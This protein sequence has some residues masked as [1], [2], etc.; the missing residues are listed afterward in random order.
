[1]P[2][3]RYRR[4]E[5]NIIMF[6]KLTQQLVSKVINDYQNTDDM[7]VRARYGSLEAITSIIVNLVLFAVKLVIGL[8]LHSIAVIA[9][10]MH[11]LSD[12]G[13]SIVVLVGFKVAR[14]PGDREHPFGHGRAEPIAALIMAVIL[15]VAGFELFKSAAA[16]LWN[17]ELQVIPI[18]WL[19]ISLL[20]IS[21]LIKEITAQFA[22][23]LGRMIQSK[24]LKADFWHHRSD[25]LSTLLVLAALAG[26]HFGWVRFDGLAGLLVALIVIYSGYAIAR[27]AISPLLGERPDSELLQQIE[28]VALSLDGVQGVHDV[29][30]H[31]YGQINLISLHIEVDEDRPVLELHDLSELVEET[32]EKKLGGSTVVHIDPVSKSHE[33]YTEIHDAVS[34]LTDKNEKIAGFHDL[35]IIGHGSRVK[36]IFDI[37]LAENILQHETTTITRQLREGLTKRLPGVRTVIKVE[38]QF[39]YS[40]NPANDKNTF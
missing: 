6:R 36:A 2:V 37:N 20:V 7:T 11:S 8:T 16:R 24:A 1:M 9:D 23:E 17:P 32:I 4:I 19:A 33:R 5:Y 25:A 3:V 26:A 27:D 35:R 14:K 18:N 10:A 31:R 21:V 40:L 13:T 22:Q 28:T 30:V 12:T 34:E 29:I 39:A 38:P 15:I